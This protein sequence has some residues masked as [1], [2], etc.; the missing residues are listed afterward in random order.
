ML[1]NRARQFVA[2]YYRN[3]GGW[4]TRRKLL[5]IESDDW[6]SIRMPSRAVYERCLRAGY[7][8]DQIAYERY[9]A[10]LSN[11]DLEYLFDLLASFRDRT[12]AHPV[13][14]ANCLVANP[15]FDKIEACGFQEYH[16]ELIPETFKKYPRHDR[17]FALWQEG[18]ARGVFRPQ[19]HGREHL[20]VFQFM[21]GL[22]NN[23][24]DV[25]F[26]FRNRM[27]G[28]IPK[29]PRIQ[30]NRYVE[31]TRFQSATEKEYVLRS[32]IEGL[33]L[34]Y[35]L[36]GY[37]SETL[38]P[39]NYV[40]SSDFDGPVLK[41]GVVG[42]QGSRVMREQ[43]PDGSHRLVRR[44]L[45]DKNSFGQRYLTRNATFEPSLFR[46]KI[47]T[48]VRHCLREISAAFQ[49]GKPAIITTHRLNYSGT[50]DVANRDRTLFLLKQLLA[51]VVRKWPDIEFRSSDQLLRIID[52]A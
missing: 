37:R 11:D 16:Y 3:W 47:D 20:N 25:V 22:Q 24:P 30:G 15:D 27:P 50:V 52:S 48:P 13:I 26:G 46:L 7:P 1:L 19:F 18:L 12:G 29:G 5:V 33:D 32:L 9:D 35:Q 8:V 17:S 31:A 23:D 28:C 34:F 44:R 51:A 10:P 41:S 42:F 38:I 2:P 21:K 39:T 49:M 6:G 45:G 40:W 4:R 14:T 36:F 43:Q